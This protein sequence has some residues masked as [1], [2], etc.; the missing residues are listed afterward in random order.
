MFDVV[1]GPDALQDTNAFL[2]CALSFV[3]HVIAV[4]VCCQSSEL[5]LLCRAAFHVKAV[6]YRFAQQDLLM[7]PEMLDKKS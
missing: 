5:E 2:Q 3:R 7:W 1:V 4:V 6:S